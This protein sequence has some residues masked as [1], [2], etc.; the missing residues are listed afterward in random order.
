[1]TTVSTAT[2]V[3]AISAYCGSSGAV[4]S[5]NCGSTASMKTIAFGLLELTRKARSTSPAAVARP[6]SDPVSAGV[7]AERHWRT[8]R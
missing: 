8:P 4:G 5:R 6:A 2:I 1:M 3:A 7:G